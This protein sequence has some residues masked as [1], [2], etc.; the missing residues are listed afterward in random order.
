MQPETLYQVHRR[1]DTRN[2][3]RK[4]RKKKFGEVGR[5]GATAAVKCLDGG[6]EK[7]YFDDDGRAKERKK[8]WKM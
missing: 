8:V 7:L 1:L 2:R 3:R 5:L 6:N 4:K